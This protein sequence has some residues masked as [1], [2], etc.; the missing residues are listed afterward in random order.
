MQRV[1]I[2]LLVLLIVISMLV[3]FSPKDS[4]LVFEATNSSYLIDI[5]IIDYD[6]QGVQWDAYVQK[7][8]VLESRGEIMLKGVKIHYPLRSF[9]V[10]AEEGIYSLKDNRLALKGRIKGQSNGLDIYA[11]RVRYEPKEK[12]LYAYGRLSI[13]GKGFTITADEGVIRDSSILMVKGNVR[14]VFDNI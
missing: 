3:S 5:H 9:T 11:D 14:T 13:K 6:S 4:Q 2:L 12:A 7:A 1:T 8:T 10:E